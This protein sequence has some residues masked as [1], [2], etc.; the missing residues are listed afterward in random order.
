M[1]LL[2]FL[3]ELFSENDSHVDQAEKEKQVKNANENYNKGCAYFDDNDFDEAKKYFNTAKE[4]YK[5]F[6][7][8][9]DVNDCDYWLRKCGNENE[10][11]LGINDMNEGSRLY[12]KS[13]YSKAI[14][15]YESAI[16]HFEYGDYSSMIRQ[17]RNNIKLCEDK[18]DEDIC[19]ECDEKLDY[20]RRCYENGDY[21]NARRAVEDAR[22][23]W[24]N[25]RECDELL[26][27]IDEAEEY[28]RRQEEKEEDNEEEYEYD[29][30]DEY[31]YEDD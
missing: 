11:D 23:N 1:G 28:D 14:D 26:R 27:D 7:L 13:E 16:D 17:C 3:I 6:N 5:K 15:C 21:N 12:Q 25:G 8:T 22:V 9:T 29:D 20:A 31:E 4:I 18:I 2:D 19:D 24:Y 30:E 10:Y